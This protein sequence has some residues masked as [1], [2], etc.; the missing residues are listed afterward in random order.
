MDV[1][2]R[3]D[4]YAPNGQLFR[5]D[6]AFNLDDTGLKEEDLPSSAQ[7]KRGKDWGRLQNIEG[8]HSTLPKKEEEKVP[9]PNADNAEDPPKITQVPTNSG[10]PVTPKK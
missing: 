7:V 5:K 2:L 4:W 9:D 3:N 6:R 8:L 1:K 10:S